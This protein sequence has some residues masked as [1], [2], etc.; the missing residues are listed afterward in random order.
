MQDLRSR[1]DRM[2]FAGG[3]ITLFASAQGH[4]AEGCYPFIST[5]DVIYWYCHAGSDTATRLNLH[6]Q[7]GGSDPE[8]SAYPITTFVLYNILYKLLSTLVRFIPPPPSP[9]H[10]LSRRTANYGARTDV[11][12]RLRGLSYC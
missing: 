12:A 6:R 4:F 2:I 3:L 7:L 9:N 10:P 8:L 5:K 1:L 11:G